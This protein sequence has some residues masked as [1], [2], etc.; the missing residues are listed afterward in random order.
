M[1]VFAVRGEG[2]IERRACGS[3]QQTNQ[4]ERCENPRQTYPGR[5]HGNDLI[6]AR[7]A[8]QGEEQRQEQGDRKQNHEDL[9]HLGEII[10]QDQHSRDALVE[11]GRDVVAHVEDEPDR[12]EPRD[13]VKISLQEIGQHVA[14]EPSHYIFEFRISICDLV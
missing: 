7:H 2:I 1:R 14:I 10:F 5:E 12:N 4:Q 11:K 13:A 6:G 8:A 9:R 3:R